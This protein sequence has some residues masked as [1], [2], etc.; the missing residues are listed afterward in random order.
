MAGGYPVVSSGDESVSVRGYVAGIAEQIPEV[1]VNL[2][3]I[4]RQ[5]P[6]NG[7]PGDKGGG[8]SRPA[9]SRLRTP[10]FEDVTV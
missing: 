10:D 9:Q 7:G 4:Y 8:V 6:S 2:A 1:T 3:G 5:A